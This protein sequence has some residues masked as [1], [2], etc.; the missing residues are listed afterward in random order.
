MATH[1]LHC[2]D[3]EELLPETLV[4]LAWRNSAFRMSLYHPY[5]TV[6]PNKWCDTSHEDTLRAM[7]LLSSRILSPECLE[8]GCV[9]VIRSCDNCGQKNHVPVRHLLPTGR[10]GVCKS[11][12][13]HIAEPLTVDN[14]LF[15]EIIHSSPV[16]GLV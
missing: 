16:P 11:P 6:N 8:E 1:P 2:L 9:P 12:L 3:A 7:S 5:L 4:R 14:T 10:C 13:P 15:D